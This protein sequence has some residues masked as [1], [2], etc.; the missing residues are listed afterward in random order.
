M[1]KLISRLLTLGI[2]GA[3]LWWLAGEVGLVNTGG[4]SSRGAG[5]DVRLIE[6]NLDVPD[7]SKSYGDR[8]EGSFVVYNQGESAAEYC[9]L[10]LLDGS[11]ERFALAPLARLQVRVKSASFYRTSGV[12]KVVVRIQCSGYEKTLYAQQQ[13]Y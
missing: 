3:I 2:A 13:S 1:G 10:W 7:V 9:T 12:T 5:P 4:G 11:S 6:S 8:F